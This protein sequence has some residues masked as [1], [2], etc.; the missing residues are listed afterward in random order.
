MKSEEYN[1]GYSQ[2]LKDINKPMQMI[3]EKWEPSVCPRCKET[4]SE[5]EPCH[6]GY[7]VRASTLERCPYCGQKIIWE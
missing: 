1:K 3:I 5:Y 2:A 4:F 7:Y 6:D